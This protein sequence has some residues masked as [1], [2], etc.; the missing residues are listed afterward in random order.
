MDTIAVATDFSARSARALSRAR[1]IAG[2]TRARL[3]LIHVVDD[4]QPADVIEASREVALRELEKMIDAIRSQSDIDA[5]PVVGVGDVAVGILDCAAQ[6]AAD[7]VIVGPHRKRATDVFIGTTVE[8]VLRRSPRPLLIALDA[9]PGDYVR[10]LLAVDFEEASRSAARAA[11]AL[12]VFDHTEVIVM[13]AFEAF[14]G[15][16]AGRAMLDASQTDDTRASERL[17]AVSELHA[18]LDA[19][20]L[21]TSTTRVVAM[22]GTPAQAILQSAEAEHADLVIVGTSQRKGFA[23]LLVGSIAGDVM[24]DTRRDIL[25]V[26]VA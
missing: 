15:G 1:L 25:V 20:S 26:P 11:L 14:G 13:H 22:H 12:G 7:L 2:K 6:V 19:L 16:R 17:Q 4:D 3:A 23:R 24:R 9:S 8:R 21:P 18:M 5:V 10:S